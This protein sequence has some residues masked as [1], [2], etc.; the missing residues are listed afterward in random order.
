MSSNSTD[1]HSLLP[2]LANKLGLSWIDGTII[3]ANQE[4]RSILGIKHP[5]I[6]PVV[7]YQQHEI[8]SKLKNQTLFPFASGIAIATPE[9]WQARPLFFSLPGAWSEVSDLTGNS[10]EFDSASGDTKG[11][12]LIAAS[13]LRDFDKDKQQRVVFIGDSDFA[14]NIYIGHGGNL[15]LIV[16]VLQ[17]LA[18]D[19]QRISMLPY[20]PPDISIEFS[21]TAIAALAAS[22][23]LIV[24]FGVLVIGIYIGIRRRRAR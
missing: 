2:S 1:N 10:V 3:D 21:N 16:S 14:S 13:L 17:W 20:Q 8:T 23:L 5:A 11:P 24:P 19:D 9:K 6:V 12:L 22:Y 7:E 18:H 15:T 4:L